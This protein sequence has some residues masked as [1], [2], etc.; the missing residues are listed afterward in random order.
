MRE[1]TIEAM[2]TFGGS[3]V[4]ALARAWQAADYRNRAKLFAA[5][6]D[7]FTEYEEMARLQAER[8]RVW[9]RAKDDA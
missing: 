4:Q 9:A 5:F 2:L 1:G 6:E 7:L 3:F 8:E